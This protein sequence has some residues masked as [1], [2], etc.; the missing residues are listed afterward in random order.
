MGMMMGCE[1][2]VLINP[3]LE[4]NSI[5]T[6]NKKLALTNSKPQGKPALS[7]NQKSGLNTANVIVDENGVPSGVEAIVLY[8]DMDVIQ[9]NYPNSFSGSFSQHYRNEMS[10]HF[11]IYSVDYGNSSC[12][13]VERWFV[14]KLE[15]EN[16]AGTSLTDG[17]IPVDIDEGNDNTSSANSPASS[18]S[19]PPAGWGDPNGNVSSQAPSRPNRPDA[20][21]D[22]PTGIPI[23][24]TFQACF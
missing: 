24:I 23:P 9:S 19:N 8:L 1:K 7:N 13:N 14:N 16:Y 18:T 20:P 11:T 4:S 21:D 12:G 6:G 17:V 22:T 15:Y 2:E 5:P 10:T 3:S